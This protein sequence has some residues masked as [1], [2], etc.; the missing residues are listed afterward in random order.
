M[1]I[2]ACRF[3]HYQPVKPRH[4]NSIKRHI[5]ETADS[6]NRSVARR[7]RWT[8]GGVTKAPRT[9][10]EMKRWPD[11]PLSGPPIGIGPR[12]EAESIDRARGKP[13]C[14]EPWCQWI[15]WCCTPELAARNGRRH[16]RARSLRRGDKD[17]RLARILPRIWSRHRQLCVTRLC[18]KA[19]RSR[20][21]QF[22]HF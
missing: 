7:P 19:T 18:Y 22:L 20:T 16:N 1:Y 17:R 14:Q 11:P 8:E 15:L 21:I 4:L 5:R 6:I 9:R 12:V 10:M 13:K 2:Y 3:A